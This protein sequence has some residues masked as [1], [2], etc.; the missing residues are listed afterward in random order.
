MPIAL[1]PP[2][3]TQGAAWPAIAVGCFVAFGGVLYGYDTGTI[4]G[5]LAMKFWR[6]QFSTGYTDPAD[7]MPGITASQSSE[8]VSLLSAGSMLDLFHDASTH[9]LLIMTNSF[10]WRTYC[11]TNW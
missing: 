11:C 10:L 4:G 6:N 2:P 7:H 3:G 1:R 8:I 5:I 9:L